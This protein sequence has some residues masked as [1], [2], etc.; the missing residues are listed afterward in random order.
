MSLT[1]RKLYLSGTLSSPSSSP[2]TYTWK[3]KIT[4]DSSAT[5]TSGLHSMKVQDG[6]SAL[7]YSSFPASTSDGDVLNLTPT[8]TGGSGNITYSVTSGSAAMEA[9]GLSFNNNNGRIY[10]TVADTVAGTTQA[11]TIQAEDLATGTKES[12]TKTFSF[13]SAGTFEFENWN[14]AT[15]LGTYSAGSSVGQDDDVINVPTTLDTSYGTS[16]VQTGG[17]F[18]SG[19][20]F[21]LTGN[22]V[23][24]GFISPVAMPG[25]YVFTLSVRDD[26]G[27]V[28]TTGNLTLVIS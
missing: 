22:N 20:S 27:T 14:T 4:D 16:G 18:P 13:P 23:A 1:D 8:V 9:I 28:A 17:S 19:L 24:L 6:L 21:S 26:D 3:T 12:V 15:A 2:T 25:T 11:V 10:G 5:L 7:D